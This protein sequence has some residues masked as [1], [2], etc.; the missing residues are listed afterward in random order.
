VPERCTANETSGKQDIKTQL[1]YAAGPVHTA[2]SKPTAGTTQQ[3]AD[4]ARR[5]KA[6]DSR[7]VIMAA[8]SRQV[9]DGSRQ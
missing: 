2:E 5:I 7:Q 6:A 3:I 4:S 1:K 8:D 9:T